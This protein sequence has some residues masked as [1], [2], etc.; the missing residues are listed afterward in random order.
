[1]IVGKNK[2]MKDHKTINMNQPIGSATNFEIKNQTDYDKTNLRNFKQGHKE[3][4]NHNWE[5]IAYFAWDAVNSK[6]ESQ[7]FLLVKCRECE[8]ERIFN[9]EFLVK[10]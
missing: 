9:G 5:A 1:M 4:N 8:D 7:I 6:E 3:K 2:F 10:G